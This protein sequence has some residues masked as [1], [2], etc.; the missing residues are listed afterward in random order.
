MR[1]ASSCAVARARNAYRLMP[2][3]GIFAL[4]VGHVRRKTINP[5]DKASSPAKMHVVETVT[6]SDHEWRVLTAL[7]REF[8]PDEIQ[9]P[10]LERSCGRSRGIV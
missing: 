5:G 9:E 3:K 1:T 8:A 2:A 7:K 10:A 4:G 6:F